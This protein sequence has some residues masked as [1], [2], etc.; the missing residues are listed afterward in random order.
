M[1]GA[2]LN[3]VRIPIGFWAIEKI[4]DEPFLVGTSWTYFLKAW[5]LWPLLNLVSSYLII[6]SRQEFNGE[7]SME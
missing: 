6:S 2:G 7:G 3:W 4:N 5:V 1:P